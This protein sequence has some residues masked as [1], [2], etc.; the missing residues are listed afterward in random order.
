MFECLGY[1]RQSRRSDQYQHNALA[2]KMSG[3]QPDREQLLLRIARFRAA[4]S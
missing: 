2:A 3:N 4:G 1:D